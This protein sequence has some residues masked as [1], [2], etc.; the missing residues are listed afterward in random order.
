MLINYLN[1]VIFIFNDIRSYCLKDLNYMIIRKDL[2]PR[3]ASNNYR[4]TFL[5]QKTIILYILHKIVVANL[6]FYRA[7]INR[8]RII[9]IIK[10]ST[11]ILL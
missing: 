8:A 3:H 1:I 2:S 7:L 11:N 6:G 9:E 10:Q 4:T 5:I